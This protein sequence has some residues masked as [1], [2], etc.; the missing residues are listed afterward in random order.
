MLES[1]TD[2]DLRNELKRRE[3]EKTKQKRIPLKVALTEVCQKHL[4][5]GYM[6]EDVKFNTS[7]NDNSNIGFSS[8]ELKFHFYP[9]EFDYDLTK[10]QSF[11]EKK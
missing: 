8:I 10:F 6:V 7:F 5:K 11:L 3:E 9:E 1:L 4:G 2:D